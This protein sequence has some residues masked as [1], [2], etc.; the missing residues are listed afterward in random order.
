MPPIPGFGSPNPTQ[1]TPS[2]TI[3]LTEGSQK[4]GPQQTVLDHF[5]SNKKRRTPRKKLEIV[6]LDDAKEDVEL[7]KNAHHW[8]DHWDFQLISVWGEMKNTFNAPPKRDV[9]FEFL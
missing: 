9:S 1:G 4:R 5:K 7:L 6:K 8:K 3:D 2:A